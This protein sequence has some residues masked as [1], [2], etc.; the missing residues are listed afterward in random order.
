MVAQEVSKEELEGTETASNEGGDDPS[1]P[2]SSGLGDIS[3]P[4]RDRLQPR[5]GSIKFA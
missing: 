4:I 2:R 5:G 1:E 3:Q